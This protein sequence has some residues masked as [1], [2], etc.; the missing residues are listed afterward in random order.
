MS[1][2]HAVLWSKR[3]TASISADG[4]L[5][6]TGLP[7]IHRMLPCSDLHPT[8]GSCSS[9]APSLPV[10]SLINGICAGSGTLVAWLSQCCAQPRPS[11]WGPEAVSHTLRAALCLVALLANNSTA[12]QALLTASLKPPAMDVMAQTLQNLCHSLPSGELVMP[13]SSVCGFSH[14]ACGETQP[15]GQPVQPGTTR[16]CTQAVHVHDQ[17]HSSNRSTTKSL[18]AGPSVERAALEAMLRLL[19]STLTDCP[20]AVAAFAGST[21][22]LT[23]LATFAASQY[24]PLPPAHATV[25]IA[26]WPSQSM[27]ACT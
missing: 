14:N 5:L 2:K 1:A 23:N 16:L 6:L 15:P 9:E 4:S 25:C 24:A 21:H 19:V 8:G 20:S 3:H 26:G 22:R 13:P 18:L 7:C 10:P 17:L 27:C 11:P 12:K